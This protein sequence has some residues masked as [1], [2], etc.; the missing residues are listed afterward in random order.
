MNRWPR[1]AAAGL[2]SLAIAGL[3]GLMLLDGVWQAPAL[4]LALLPTAIGV[5][6]AITANRTKT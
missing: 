5:C 1:L 6:A 2:A 3:V 4:A